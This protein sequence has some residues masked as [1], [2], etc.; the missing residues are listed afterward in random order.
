MKI[1]VFARIQN[2]IKTR[3]AIEIIKKLWYYILFL[4]IME[5]NK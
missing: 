5:I 1:I 2:D 4:F 3:K